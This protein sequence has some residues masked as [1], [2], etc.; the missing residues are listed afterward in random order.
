MLRDANLL[1]SAKTPFKVL[2]IFNDERL[3]YCTKLLKVNKVKL[4]VLFTLTKEHNLE[5]NFCNKKIAVE[6]FVVVK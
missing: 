6:N 2:C 1:G 4:F 5:N 3:I